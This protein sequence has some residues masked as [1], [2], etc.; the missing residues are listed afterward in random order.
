[1]IRRTSQNLRPPAK[2]E[3]ALSLALK[4]AMERAQAKRR[5]SGEA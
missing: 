3:S 1:M 5:Q 2:P 4:A